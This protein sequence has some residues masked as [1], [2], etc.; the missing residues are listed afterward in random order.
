MHVCT[1]LYMHLPHQFFAQLVSRNMT[2]IFGLESSVFRALHVD[3]QCFR[4]RSW[5]S[6]KNSGMLYMMCFYQYFP[7]SWAP[8][9]SGIVITFS[10]DEEKGNFHSY[11][12]ILLINWGWRVHQRLLQIRSHG[13]NRPWLQGRFHI[14][15]NLFPLSKLLHFKFPFSTFS[16]S[17]TTIKVKLHSA[18][19]RTQ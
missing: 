15:Q 1:H 4:A 2:S 6:K 11:F 19:N 17:F 9:N 10:K 18:R 3:I 13:F 7:T 16:F 12:S 5:G 8:K 14:I